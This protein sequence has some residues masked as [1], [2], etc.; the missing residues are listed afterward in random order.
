MAV[1]N[2]AYATHPDYTLRFTN[3]IDPKRQTAIERALLDASRWIE[4]QFGVFYGKDASVVA[5][6]FKAKYYDRLDLDYEGDCPGIAT[7]VG[8]I[9]QVDETGS[10]DFGTAWATTDYD[11]EPRQAAYAPQPLPWNTIRR[12]RNG[13]K[14]FTIGNDVKVT[15]KFGYPSVPVVIRDGVVEL[16]GILLGDSA[17]ASRQFTDIGTVGASMEARKIVEGMANPG[18]KRLT[19]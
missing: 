16:A 9:I 6:L 3:V 1:L 8:L 11:L 7:T 13:S 10:G 2:D 15:A 5:R 14:S 19:F 12:R 18:N 17:L 4:T